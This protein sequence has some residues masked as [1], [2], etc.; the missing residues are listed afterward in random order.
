MAVRQRGL[1]R[2]STATTIVEDIDQCLLKIVTGNPVQKLAS[3]AC[4]ADDDR[5]ITWTHSRGVRLDR[6]IDAGQ[7]S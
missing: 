2:V 4:V 1:V 6:H 7:V 3:L 5:Q